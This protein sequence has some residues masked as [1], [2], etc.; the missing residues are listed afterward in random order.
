MFTD[1]TVELVIAVWR[2]ITVT[3]DTSTE[4]TQI[5]EQ[6]QAAEYFRHPQSSILSAQLCHTALS[7]FSLSLPLTFVSR[8]DL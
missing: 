6:P 2:Q 3:P 4:Y 5:D 7:V 1:L 8:R